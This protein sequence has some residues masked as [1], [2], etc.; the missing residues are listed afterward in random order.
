VRCVGLFRD[1]ILGSP[2]ES[3]SGSFDYCFSGGKL[4]SVKIVAEGVLRYWQ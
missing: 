1:A 4:E 2:F 3:F